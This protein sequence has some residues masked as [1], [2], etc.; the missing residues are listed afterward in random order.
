MQT[1]IYAKLSSAHI[2]TYNNFIQ[3]LL[4]TFQSNDFNQFS[5][6]L[7][8]RKLTVS[9]TNSM[10]NKHNSIIIK[11]VVLLNLFD[12]IRLSTTTI[13][14]S[15]KSYF[16]VTTA[17]VEVLPPPPPP[18]PPNHPKRADLVDPHLNEPRGAEIVEVVEEPT[19]RPSDIVKGMCRSMSALC[20]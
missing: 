17:S 15:L 5:L 8:L 20:K 7:C 2:N 6:P 12:K 9:V 10:H 16:Q 1:L 3:L 13:L 11:T 19:L 18:P 14:I 4:S